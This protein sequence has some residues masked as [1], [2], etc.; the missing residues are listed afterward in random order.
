M[1]SLGLEGCYNIIPASKEAVVVRVSFSSG[2]LHIILFE[3]LVMVIQACF[4]LACQ[5]PI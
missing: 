2:V 3:V 5:C 4:V 1:Y